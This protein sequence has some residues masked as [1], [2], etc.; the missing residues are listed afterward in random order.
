MMLLARGKGDEM[1]IKMSKKKGYIVVWAGLGIL[2]GVALFAP[3]LTLHDPYEQNLANRF[4][5]PSAEYWL[6]TDELGR[7]VFSR[8][9]VGTRMSLFIGAAVVSINAVVGSLIGLL[10]GFGSRWIDA[11]VMGLLDIVQAFPGAILTLA[12]AGILG[13]GLP[14]MIL[15]LTVLGWAGHARFVRSMVLSLNEREFIESARSL[16]YGSFHVLFRHVL[17]NCLGPILV[18]S[19]MEM[20]GAIMMAAGLNFL[21]LGVPVSTPEWGAML[22]QGK[23]YFRTAP[24]LAAFPGLAIMIAAL[25]FNL[26]GDYL[27][28]RIDE[29]GLI[30][31]WKD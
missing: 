11:L 8:L 26:L 21:G 13:P 31:E 18:F 9:V 27:R 7:C 16:G 10:S 23:D 25:E 4:A 30:D 28:D 17:P 6:G 29:G 1:M 3:W 15:A 24:H 12:V 22:N 2:L 14:N 5:P 19:S 20:A